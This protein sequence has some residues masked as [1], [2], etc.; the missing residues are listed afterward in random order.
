[1]RTILMAAQMVI[2]ALPGSVAWAGTPAEIQIPG[3][4]VFPESLTSSADGTV[5]VGS[6]VMGAIFRARP[7]AD[8]ASVWIAPGTDGLRNIFGV[9]ADDRSN[10]L[11]VC[12]NTLDPSGHAQPSHGEL[13]AVDMLSGAS[14][15]RYPFP[16]VDAFCND[17]A[18]SGDG[19]VYATD[20]NGM[21]VVR[22]APGGTKLDVWSSGSFGERGGLLD[23]I[24]VVGDSVVVNTYNTGRM[25]RIPVTGDGVAGPA[26]EIAL[27]RPV[28]HPDGMRAFGQRG[29]LLIEGGGPGALSK[30]VFT[31]A[32]GEVSIVKQGY[33][34]GP[35]GVTLV[36]S[37]AYVVESQFK[38]LMAGPNAKTKPFHASAVQVGRP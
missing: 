20:S 22:L 36:G 23:G 10:T 30:I 16:S 27:S 24:A 33:P 34:D 19:T 2:A 18:V 37:L 32:K 38:A 25:F 9:Y 13:H 3:D 29:A 1:M 7:G 11:W 14:K 12:S 31:G 8:A 17:I 28:D 21:Q 6:V 35:V 4:H 15:G 26:V 5:Y